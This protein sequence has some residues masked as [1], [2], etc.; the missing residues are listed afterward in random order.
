MQNAAQDLTH[1][2]TSMSA[3]VEKFYAKKIDDVKSI[4]NEIMYSEMQYHAK[5]LE[6]L[7]QLQ[8]Q[9]AN[10]DVES[11]IYEVRSKLRADTKLDLQ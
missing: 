1:S 10:T 8:G 11:D 7:S 9:L 2:N 5:A 6:V 4:L 3:N